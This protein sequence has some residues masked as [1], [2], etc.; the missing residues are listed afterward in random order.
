MTDDGLQIENYGSRTTVYGLRI[1]DDGSRFTDN[2]L[3][4]FV[5]GCLLEVESWQ[6]IC[7]LRRQKLE[8]FVFLLRFVCMKVEIDQSGKVEQ[9]RLDTVIALS[10]SIQYSIVLKRTD[11]RLLKQLFKRL[12]YPKIYI[13]IVFAALVSIC[14]YESKH[15]GSVIVDTEYPGHNKL[16]GKSIRSSLKKLGAKKFPVIRFGFVGKRS[17]SH[18]LA[19]KVSHKKLKPDRIVSLEELLILTLPNKKSGA[20]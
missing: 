19:A 16:I 3:P 14:I 9:T 18:D 11:K 8:I 10:N 20:A 6:L 2:G 17:P 1:A 15:E 4:L 5:G 13:Q 12:G 7:R